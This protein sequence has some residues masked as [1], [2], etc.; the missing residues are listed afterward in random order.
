[1]APKVFNRVASPRSTLFASYQ[2]FAFVCSWSFFIPMLTFQTCRSCIKKI[3]HNFSLLNFI[4]SLFNTN[5]FYSVFVSRI[6]AV[7]IN[8]KLIP[9]ITISSSTVSR[10]VPAISETMAR[11]SFNR[12]FNKVDF[13]T[14]GS[15]TMATGI[16]F[17]Q[18][19]S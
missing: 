9:S 19:V 1:M 3:K 8:R 2:L 5:T 12:A 7:S 4:K 10:V 6:P 11:S 13:P 14:F 18:D 16:P 17:F 15:P